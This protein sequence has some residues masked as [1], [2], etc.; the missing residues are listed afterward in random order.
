[1]RYADLPP[2]E[3]SSDEPCETCGHEWIH[4]TR[5]VGKTREAAPG[6]F[7][8][9][10]VMAP[11]DGFGDRCEMCCDAYPECACPG[12]CG[13]PLFV[14]SEEAAEARIEVSR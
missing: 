9:L 8:D 10:P 13:C 7:V 2:E 4:H 14:S 11:C 3:R 12:K 6:F 1:M 5:S